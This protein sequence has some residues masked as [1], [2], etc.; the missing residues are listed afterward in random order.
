[1][2]EN[3]FVA[4][5][6]EFLEKEWRVE[7][8]CHFIGYSYLFIAF[9]KCVVHLCPIYSYC[10]TFPMPWLDIVNYKKQPN[11]VIWIYSYTTSQ[12]YKWNLGPSTLLSVTTLLHLL[13]PPS[14]FFSSFSSLRSGIKDDLTMSSLLY[15]IH[16]LHYI[17]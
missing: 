14:Y 8:Q 10:V 7:K 2:V 1:M 4:I 12:H 17:S 3:P 11:F 16:S 9:Y 5:K 15:C 6:S 13:T